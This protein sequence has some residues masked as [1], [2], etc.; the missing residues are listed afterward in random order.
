MELLDKIL[1]KHHIAF[2][3]GLTSLARLYSLPNP[4]KENFTINMNTGEANSCSCESTFK[5]LED[6]LPLLVR[7][8]YLSYFLQR[9]LIPVIGS[10]AEERTSIFHI[11]YIMRDFA[12]YAQGME[13]L[14]KIKCT[15]VIKATGARSSGASIS[16][17]GN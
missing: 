16:T 7:C 9:V 12:E 11:P 14:V 13:P 1:Y 5:L 2:C 8:D 4:K 15:V 6:L 10:N 17:T 3:Q